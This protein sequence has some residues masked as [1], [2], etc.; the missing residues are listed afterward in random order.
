[1]PLPRQID[2]T[3]NQ[4]QDAH[5]G[6]RGKHIVFIP[7]D[8]I[9]GAEWN[10][11]TEQWNFVTG[12]KYEIINYTPGYRHPSLAKASHETDA[13]IYVRGHGNPGAPYIQVKVDVGEDAVQERKI[14]ITEAC[15]RLIAMGL[16]KSYRGAIK[17]YS[18][19]SGTILT[20]AAYQHELRRLESHNRDVKSALKQG[21]ITSQQA[22]H[23]R[24]EI[25]PNKSIARN[26][27]D[28]MR[29]KGFNTCVFY[30][31][32]GPLASEYAD[33]GTGQ[34]HKSVELH[35]LHNPPAHLA[36]LGTKRASIGRVQA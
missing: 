5:V 31:Y 25:H 14:L 36:A 19:Y 7:W 9:E 3:R 8:Q 33:D 28:Y 1:M 21:M 17:F 22:E 6:N 35:G 29:T 4:P 30:G 12:N 32:L 15:D 27:A 23:F 24:K 20:T 11:K 13:V 34:W 18:C 16:E 26:G 2:V 10:L